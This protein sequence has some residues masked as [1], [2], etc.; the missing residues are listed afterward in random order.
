MSPDVCAQTAGEVDIREIVLEIACGGILLPGIV[1]EPANA[2]TATDVAMLIIVGGPQYRAGSHRQFVQLAR[3]VAH[4]GLTV[5]RFD[6]RGM[7]D[8]DGAMRTFENA[9]PDLH[10][11]INALLRYAPHAQGVILWG[12]CDAASLAL[13]HGS[14]HPA[15]LGVA[16]ANPWVRSEATLAAVT[17]KHY[18][19]SRLLQK[20]LWYKVL[21]G[22]FDFRESLRSL[23]SNVAQAS[24]SRR[25]QRSGDAPLDFQIRMARGLAA[26]SGP[27]LLMLSGD[28]LT[29]REFV[30]YTAT[31]PAWA[32]LLQAARVSHAAIP[33]ADHTFSLRSWRGEVEQQT[34]AWIRENFSTK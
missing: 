7:G 4:E 23:W 31:A 21:S 32:G 24:A 2:S 12:L 1:A 33:N 5:L 30:E 14:A 19:G 17:V 27:V 29:A 13:M 6:Y 25:G 20:D 28:D 10:A 8:A 22:R 3:A 26:F 9:A 16:L 15:V 34:C 11:A 18:Y